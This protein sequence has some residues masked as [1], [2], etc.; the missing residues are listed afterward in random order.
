MIG[1]DPM[2]MMLMIGGGIDRAKK[3][4]VAK[5]KG[6]WR[7]AREGKNVASRGHTRIPVSLRPTMSQMRL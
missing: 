6:D 5:K 1:R 4:I 2:L 7:K 3:G